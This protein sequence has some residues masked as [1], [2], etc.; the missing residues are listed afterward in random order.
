MIYTYYLGIDVSKK[1][2]DLCL[3]LPDGQ[4]V[5]AKGKN[6]ANF[7]G[8]PLTTFLKKNGVADLDKLLVCAEHTGHYNNLLNPQFLSGGFNLWLADP[9]DL[10]YSQGLTRGKSDV[11]DAERI[12]LYAKRFEDKARLLRPSKQ[13]FKDLAYLTA[14]REVLVVDKA[15]YRAQLNDEK[16]FF[17]P[18]IFKNKEKRYKRLI[19][20][21]REAINEIDAEIDALLNSNQDLKEQYEICTS[22]DGIGRQTA[23]ETIV[24]TE[25]FTKITSPKKFACHAGCAPFSYTSGTSIWSANRVSRKADKKLKRLFHMAAVSVIRINGEMRTYFIRK[26]AEGKSKMSVINAI[27]NKLI[28]RIFALIRDKRKYEKKYINHMNMS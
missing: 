11:V 23:V 1:T 9:S 2:L 13:A 21:L 25:G 18:G 3:L 7:V 16:A 15:K 26:V 4:R 6:S 20:N 17:A 14:Q 28:G 24:K 27:R 12:A 8:G 22:I 5:F 10:H 19:K